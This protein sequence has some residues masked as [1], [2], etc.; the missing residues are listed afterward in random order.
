MSN[1]ELE[2]A[3]DR[4]YST[5]LEPYFYSLKIPDIP[6]S[7][8]NK[9]PVDRFLFSSYKNI[10]IELKYTST[11]R[12]ECRR[13]KDHQ[14]HDLKEFKSKAGDSYLLFSLNKFNKIFLVEID[15]YLTFKKNLG[16]NSFTQDHLDLMNYQEIHA[17][18]LRKYYRLDLQLLIP[19]QMFIS[20]YI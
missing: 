13:I 19:N 3:F 9:Q 2:K 6:F 11:D 20:S 16:Q 4:G 5:Y 15:D 14:V 1:S 18:K 7:K 8:K 17:E 10:A 12:M